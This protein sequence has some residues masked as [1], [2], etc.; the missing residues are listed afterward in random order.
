MSYHDYPPHYLSSRDKWQ[1]LA[2]ET[3]KAGEATFAT[4]LRC[5]LPPHYEVIEKP[6]KLKIYEGGKG[7]KPDTKII[8]HNTGRCLYVEKKTGNNGGNAHERVFKYCTKGI[9]R[10]TR[11]VD[12]SVVD[13][14]FFLVF[15]GDTFQRQQYQSKLKVDLEGENYAIMD[16][17]FANINEVAQ[18][19][20]EIL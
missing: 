11:R 5:T 16:S 17:G 1:D 7:I 2:A 9:K 14:P 4:A 18:Q 15:S 8:N 3:G 20:M 6:P 19:I 13:D 10:H 12:P